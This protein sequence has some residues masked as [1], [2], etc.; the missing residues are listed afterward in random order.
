MVGHTHANERKKIWL[1]V[2]GKVLETNRPEDEEAEIIC[3]YTY[4]LRLHWSYP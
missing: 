2:V 4:L 1:E 3:M